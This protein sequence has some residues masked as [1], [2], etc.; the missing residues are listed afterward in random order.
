LNIS[1]TRFFG[2]NL[3]TDLK[4]DG[5]K[6]LKNGVFMLFPRIFGCAKILSKISGLHQVE[7]VPVFESPPLHTVRPSAPP[8]SGI[9]LNPQ[10]VQT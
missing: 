1:G 8:D 7:D 3:M 10:L 5:Q 6:E 4:L 9:A 2:E